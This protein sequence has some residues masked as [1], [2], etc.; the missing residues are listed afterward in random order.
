[1]IVS[2]FLFFPGRKKVFPFFSLLTWRQPTSLFIDRHNEVTVYFEQ[3][4]LGKKERAANLPLSGA[5]FYLV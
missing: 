2:L 1:L 3:R 4:K 5:R